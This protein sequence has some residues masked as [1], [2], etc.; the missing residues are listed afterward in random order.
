[1]GRLQRKLKLESALVG[2]SDRL[3]QQVDD[4][5]QL[6][7]VLFQ[8]RVVEQPNLS[9]HGLAHGLVESIPKLQLQEQANAG[10][11]LHVKRGSPHFLHARYGVQPAVLRDCRQF[12]HRLDILIF[13]TRIPPLP[14][15]YEP[16]NLGVN[17]LR[18]HGPHPSLVLFRP[19]VL[20]FDLP[21][22]LKARANRAVGVPYLLVK[23]QKHGVGTRIGGH[24]RALE[25]HVSR[26]LA[27]L[28]CQHLVQHLAQHLHQAATL[29][30]QRVLQRLC[31]G[32]SGQ[33]V[34]AG[35]RVVGHQPFIGVP[36]EHHR[37][38]PV[39]GHFVL[40]KVVVRG[41]HAGVAMIRD[42]AKAQVD[43]VVRLHAPRPVFAEEVEVLQRKRGH[44]L[45]HS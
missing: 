7:P 28:C 42:A 2:Y 45:P 27:F 8:V 41:E 24:L 23:P 37:R 15:I 1:M 31:R 11:E 5:F 36:L 29:P 40:V 16:H 26:S 13:A 12:P 22:L 39:L 18:G 25:V 38:V 20:T 30:L 17:R 3:A 33:H 21:L 10:T 43:V 19:P 14:I 44:Y 34:P 9:S 32:A 6:I 35:Q 4:P